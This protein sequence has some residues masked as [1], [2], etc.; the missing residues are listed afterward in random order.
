MIKHDAVSLMC[1]MAGLRPVVI[2]R[3]AYPK[4]DRYAVEYSY[5]FE[6]I[7]RKTGDI[8]LIEIRKR[9]A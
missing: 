1:R 4:W 5:I 6:A 9:E 3:E 7:D 2:R 8:D